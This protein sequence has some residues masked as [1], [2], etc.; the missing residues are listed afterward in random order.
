MKDECEEKYVF[1][2]LATADLDEAAGCLDAIKKYKR[3]LTRTTMV[4]NAIIA[5]SRPFMECKGTNNKIHRLKIKVVPKEYRTLHK[6]VLQ[7]RNRIIAHTD[8]VFRNPKLVKYGIMMKRE[9]DYLALV[10]EMQVL[11]REVRIA[12]HNMIIEYGRR[13]IK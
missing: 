6:K 1:Y 10:G 4:K 2:N 8:L 11:T 5:Y 3:G 13:F 7:Y 12:V 9:G